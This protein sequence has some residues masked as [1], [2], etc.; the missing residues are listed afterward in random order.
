MYSGKC[1]LLSPS[2][3]KCRHQLLHYVSLSLTIHS[4]L[5][6]ALFTSE[7]SYLFPQLVFSSSNLLFCFDCTLY[8]I[9][10]SYLYDFKHSPSDCSFKYSIPIGYSDVAQ[11]W[12]C[13]YFSREV[14]SYHLL[15]PFL[16]RSGPIATI[17]LLQAYLY[18]T[19]LATSV[20]CRSSISSYSNWSCFY[21][22]CICVTSLF[23]N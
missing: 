7:V 15:S 2:N 19:T 20:H 23:W 3:R 13:C 14:I 18:C 17:M 10:F 16:F 6:Y 21:Q 8:A 4:S 11:H 12:P 5:V 1:S 22:H 9:I